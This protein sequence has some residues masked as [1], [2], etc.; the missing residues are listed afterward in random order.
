MSALV[1]WFYWWEIK[2]WCF[3]PSATLLIP[4]VKSQHHVSLQVK[5][6][7]KAQNIN[8]PKKGT[9]NS[10][11]LCLLVI[12]HFQVSF[13]IQDLISKLFFTYTSAKFT[14][15]SHS[16]PLISLFY[17]YQTCVPA[18]LP[19][20]KEIYDG[21]VAEGKIDLLYSLWLSG[22]PVPGSLPIAFTCRNSVLW[23]ETCWW[24]LYG[25][26]SKVS[27]P[28]QG[29]KKSDLSFMSLRTLFW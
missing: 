16:L 13:L 7:A 2:D 14:D 17:I 18:I 12:F 28:E 3:F 11:S 15:Y 19:P 22:L 23:W 21:N 1:I 6:W 25:K 4:R 27:T 10:Y 26:Y 24:G 20:L 29:T 9:L 5:E 8:D